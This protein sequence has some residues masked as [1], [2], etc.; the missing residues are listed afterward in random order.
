MKNL[1]Y[2]TKL[3]FLIGIA[4]VGYVLFRRYLINE[5]KNQKVERVDLEWSDDKEQSNK[6]IKEDQKTINQLERLLRK[7]QK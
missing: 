2:G 6:T 5:S 1:L 3:L 7:Y 4:F